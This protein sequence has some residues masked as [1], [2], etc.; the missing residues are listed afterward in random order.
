MCRDGAGAAVLAA[1]SLVLDRMRRSRRRHSSRLG[2]EGADPAE[3][4]ETARRI[5]GGL[6]SG[7]RFALGEGG[8]DGG[9]RTAVGAMEQPQPPDPWEVLFEVGS[10]YLA[11]SP[12]SSSPGGLQ[13]PATATAA[14]LPLV[15]AASLAPTS[16]HSVPEVMAGTVPLLLAQVG[17]G[18][19]PD[20]VRAL[21]S[22]LRSCFPG[23][24][25][26][27]LDPPAEEQLS[28]VRSNLRLNRWEVPGEGDEA[29]LR[30]IV[31]DMVSP[32]PPPSG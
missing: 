1:A 16:R 20:L 19:D 9:H 4:D 15:V 8:A 23:A 26:I 3:E 29:L 22:L 14:A 27:A 5:L 2:G 12:P 25:G 28:L 21:E 30:R 17:D 32:R 31:E 11:P 10:E 13:R 18:L 6:L 24:P 7:S